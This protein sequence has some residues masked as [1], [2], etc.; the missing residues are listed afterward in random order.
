MG[1]GAVL[2]DLEGVG[3]V[4]ERLLDVGDRLV[5]DL[6]LR[7][8]GG[9]GIV[10]SLHGRI[11][12]EGFLDPGLVSLV[13]LQIL[14][15][16]LMG[17]DSSLEI[18]DTLLHSSVFSL[19]ILDLLLDRGDVTGVGGNLT[20]EGLDPL[21]QSDVGSLQILDGLLGS[22]DRLGVLGLGSLERSDLVLE[23][24]DGASIRIHL[25]LEAVDVFRIVLRTASVQK[26]S[27]RKGAYQRYSKKFF[28][29]EI[30]FKN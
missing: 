16:S 5:H 25:G 12:L 6:Q 9:D 29:K 27:T 30:I 21:V 22:L 14:E 1:S 2:D 24:V 11:V 10:E 28:H 18:G 8:E 4:T 19:Q 20:L 15:P 3:E 23:S 7:V 26:G 17:L 13:G